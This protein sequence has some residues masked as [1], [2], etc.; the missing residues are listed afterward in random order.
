MDKS[1]FLYLEYKK[2]SYGTKEQFAQCASCHMFSGSTCLLM[3]KTQK[4]TPTMTCGFYSNGK[5]QTDKVGQESNSVT[6]QEAG[7][8]DAKVRCENCHFF[9]DSDNDCQLFKVLNIDHKVEPIACCNAWR[10]HGSD[11]D[12]I[13]PKTISKP[14]SAFDD[15]SKPRTLKK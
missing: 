10:G 5:P 4:I 7:L 9:Q 15:K 13:K 14:Q 2:D 12:I 8:L 11:N 3:S 1:V 6:P